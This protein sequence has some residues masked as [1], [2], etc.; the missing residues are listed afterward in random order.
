MTIVVIQC[1]VTSTR[2]SEKALLPLDNKPLIFW[3]L[4]AMKKVPAD[5]YWL[6]CDQASVEK[7]APIA[8]NCGWNCFAGPEQDVLE[9][10]CLL[11][12]KTGADIIVRATGDNPF[13]F[14]EAA[15]ASITEFSRQNG[16][17]FTFTNL[18]HGSGVE[19]FSS[20]AIL[21]ARQLTKDLYDHEHVGPALYNHPEHFSA[22]FMPAP[23]EWT[24]TQ[25]SYRTT[26]DTIAD[27]RTA[28]R[29][30]RYTHSQGKIA[31]YSS[32]DI[33]KSLSSPYVKNPILLVP[34]IQEGRGTG[35]LRRCLLIAEQN[36]TKKDPLIAADIFIQSTI[37]DKSHELIQKSIQT[38]Y[39]QK[40][41]ILT[42]FPQN[43]EYALVVTDAFSLDTQLAKKLTPIAP[44]IALDEGST[45]TKYFDYMLNIL[46]PLN[47]NQ[48]V[49]LFAPY[50]IPLPKN[51][52]GPVHTI[53]KILI[54]VGGE[55]PAGFTSLIFT[56]LKNAFPDGSVQIDAPKSGSV[57]NLKEKLHEYDLVITHYGFTAFE[58][59]IAG[60]ALILLK[61]SP[62]HKK[63]AKMYGCICL[64][65]ANCSPK[66]LQAL[67]KKPNTLI[68]HRLKSILHTPIESDTL[69]IKSLNSYIANLA[70]SKRYNCPLCGKNDHINEIIARDSIKTL[71]RCKKCHMIYN[72]FC[73]APNTQYTQSYFFEEY[74][75]QYGKTY[76]EDFEK[77]KAQGHRRLTHINSII[78][79]KKIHHD[80]KRLLDIGCAFGPFLS[81]AHESSWIP[82]GTDISYDAVSYVRNSLGF[83]ATEA[84]FPKF[85]PLASF[86]EQCPP[87]GTFEAVT[88]WYVIEHFQNL[89]TVLKAL[90]Q[91][92]TNGG[93]FAFSTPNAS[94]ISRRFNAL[95]FFTQSPHDHFSLWEPSRTKKIL[96]TYGFKVKKIISTGYHKNR[97]P[98]LLRLLPEC[99]LATLSRLFCLGDT[100]EVYCIKKDL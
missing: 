34:A 72:A 62:I 17:Y 31:P 92:V 9:R 10:F 24:S 79:T 21:K 4:R 70:Q 28:C 15:E 7:L 96:V 48:D 83:Y 49:N 32:T 98:L 68:P 30:V 29:I 20:T 51:R 87:H 23:P 65:T 25:E 58:A 5:E 57:P 81:A 40:D 74:K 76:I 3:T 52:R 80:K 88:M 37:S 41:Q 77:I 39:L 13:L 6:A 100:F 19:V 27:Y 64:S 36:Q 43:G 97:F 75:N 61:T 11:A 18:P 93:I 66:H 60:C 54:S 71:R 35:H 50:L 82:Y 16:D 38:N 67:F 44:L 47:K 42:D 46:P 33:L 73:R 89:D 59:A 95:H 99:I 85:D 56:A 86:G 26:V 12:E 55:D 8:H 14:Y 91:L 78:A 2:L 69:S 53:Q 22:V 45:H 84:P 1:R 90:S 94:G 63:L